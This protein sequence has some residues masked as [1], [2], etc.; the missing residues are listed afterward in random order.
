ML[1]KGEIAQYVN[2]ICCTNITTWVWIPRTDIKWILVIHICNPCV[3]AVRQDR[4]RRILDILQG[5]YISELK[6]KWHE[7]PSQTRWK[8]W[9]GIPG[10]PATSTHALFT[11]T[12]NAL[13]T[14]I[15]MKRG[16]S[17]VS[18]RGTKGSK[19]IRAWSEC[20][21]TSISLSKNELHWKI[22][23]KDYKCKRENNKARRRDGEF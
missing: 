6:G 17:W 3:P 22:L 1:G 8:A 4:H 19:R 15:S 13:H 12:H 14:R 21:Q 18:S 11:S 10:C 23:F 2:H 9:I 5:S 7:A 20:I 16:I